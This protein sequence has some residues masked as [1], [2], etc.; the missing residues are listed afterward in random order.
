MKPRH[1]NAT[2]GLIAAAGVIG[3]IVWRLLEAGAPAATPVTLANTGP[4]AVSVAEVS[5]VGTQP[6]LVLKGPWALVAAPK[7]AVGL[8]ASAASAAGPAAP[9]FNAGSLTLAP[10]RP[11]ELAVLLQTPQPV[12]QTCALEPRPPGE[13]TLSVAVSA[14]ES[15]HSS[16]TSMACSFE[17]KAAA[18]AAA[19]SSP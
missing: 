16:S 10:G 9:Q 5:V 14:R 8:P 12:R 7:R 13:C 6:P 3:F 17:C 15:G 1:L 18:A 2:L 11:V 19:A 4:S